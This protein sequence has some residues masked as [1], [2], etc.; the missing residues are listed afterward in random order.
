MTKRDWMMYAAGVLTTL[1]VCVLVLIAL[2]WAEW[3]L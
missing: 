3:P 1:V 2:R